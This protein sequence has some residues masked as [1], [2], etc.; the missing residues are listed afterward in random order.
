MW[1]AMDSQRVPWSEV[2]RPRLDAASIWAAAM[3]ARYAD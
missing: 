1:V 3:H 2:K